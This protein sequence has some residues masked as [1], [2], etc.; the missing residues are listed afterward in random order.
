MHVSVVALYNAAGPITPLL[1]GRRAQVVLRKKLAVLLA[2]VMMLGV[3]SA[4]P[5]L[6]QQT[7][8]QVGSGNVA[9][10]QTTIQAEVGKVQ[11][12]RSGKC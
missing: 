12:S 11:I 1:Y 6:A 10:V 5:A 3:M 4:A 9:C 2:T 7:V 8:T